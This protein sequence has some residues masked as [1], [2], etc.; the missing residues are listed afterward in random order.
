MILDSKKISFCNT[1]RKKE[2][3]REKSENFTVHAD[4]PGKKI[5]NSIRCQTPKSEINMNWRLSSILHIKIFNCFLV[6]L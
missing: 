3:V 6:F 5:Q 4:F 2:S 1:K